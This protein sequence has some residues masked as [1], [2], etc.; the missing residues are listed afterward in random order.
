MLKDTDR[1]NANEVL[2]AM[3]HIEEYLSNTVTLDDLLCNT[4]VYD[5]VMMNFILIGEACKRLSKELKAAN[6]QVDWKGLNGYRNFI[7][8][9]YFGVDENIVW[10]AIKIELPK[11]K[12]ELEAILKADGSSPEI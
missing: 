7:A 3:A 12:Q 1:A 10:A 5:A 6:P 4:L 11:L 2:Y 8:H 9:E